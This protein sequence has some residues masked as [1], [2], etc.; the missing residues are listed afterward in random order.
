MVLELDLNPALDYVNNMSFVGWFWAYVVLSYILCLPI[1][2][3]L[4]RT[5]CS[6]S[7]EVFATWFLILSPI[8]CAASLIAVSFAAL[9]FIPIITFEM[10]Y[11]SFNAIT[12]CKNTIK[13]KIYAPWDK[14]TF[15]KIEKGDYSVRCC[16][17]DIKTNCTVNGWYCTLCNKV[18]QNYFWEV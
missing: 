12:S 4:Y 2:R 17:C 11:K 7:D 1:S 3:L 8:S 14:K 18:V 13:N 10:I 6:D 9:I 5:S 15:E 16:K